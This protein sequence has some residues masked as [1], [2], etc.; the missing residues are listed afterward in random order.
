[1][2]LS[3]LVAGTMIAGTGVALADKPADPGREHGLCTA[4]FNGQKNGHEKQ[5][6]RNGEYPGPFQDL[7]EGAPDGPDEGSDGGSVSDLYNYCQQFGI[8]GNPGENGRFQECFDG[9]GTDDDTDP[10]ND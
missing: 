4:F 5:R 1:M 10:C 6:E 9:D 7:L 2:F 8:G 3:A